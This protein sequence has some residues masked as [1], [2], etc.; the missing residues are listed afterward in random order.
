MTDN[1]ADRPARGLPLRGRQQALRG[2]AA[3]LGFSAA[4][5]GSFSLGALVANDIGPVPL[6]TARFLLAAILLAL[7]VTLMPAAGR[8]GRRGYSRADGAAS[9]RYVVLA[10]LYGGYFV[11]MFEGLKTANPVAAGAVFTLTPLMT[12]LVAWP[13]LGQH[14][15]GSVMAV[16]GLGALGAVWVIFRGD[17]SALLGFELGRGEAI[18]FL[19]CVLHVFYTPSL[20]LLNRGES[21]LVTASLVTLTGFV[22]FL[23]WGW[24]EI[25]ATDWAALPPLVWVVMV[26][27][28][29]FATAF[30]ASAMQFAAQRLPASKVMAYTYATPAWI[31]L[32]E[33]ALGHG[34]ALVAV[35]PGIA[36]IA[37]ALA[38]LLRAD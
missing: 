35:L 5:S 6:T 21:A 23:A 36:V 11:L 8:G 33:L 12:A 17:I 20:R 27:L 9:W 4:V 18:Y 25:V 1:A 13:L 3:M 29:V 38:L 28:A 37:L 10:V 2:H 30:A 16:L 7:L 34:V 15:R 32:W 26:Y 14:P 24:A 22:L 31:I 19:G